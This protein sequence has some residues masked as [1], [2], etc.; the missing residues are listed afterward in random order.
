MDGTTLGLIAVAVVFVLDFTLLFGLVVLKD[1]HRRR[2]QRRE[3]RRARYVALL[4]RHLA[5]A[6]HIDEIGPDVADDDAFLDA[7]ID[8]RNV[9]SG[10]EV[11]TLSGIVDSL[12]LSDRQVA[13]LRSRFPLGRRLRAAVSLAE[14][15]DE[16]TASVL[17]EH[18]ADRE[19]EIRI[20][21]ARGLG[22][23]RHTV[24]ID[25]ILERLSIED[26][27]VRVRF[28]DT[29]VGF[30]ARATW[31]L[32]AY[33][34]VNLGHDGNKGVIEA[35]RVLGAIGDR[36]VGPTLAGIL[37][38]ARDPEV[39]IAAIE[40][41]GVVGGPL[42]V[43]PLEDAFGSSDWRLRAKSATALGEIG[44]PSVNPV[45]VNG[46]TDPEWWVRRNSAAALASLPGGETLLIE[47]IRSDDGFA[48]DAAAEALADSGALTSARERH[49]AGR[50]T[51]D[52]LLLLE[53]VATDQVVPA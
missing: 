8:L 26:S 23:M 44:D 49:E 34:R 10:A 7:V 53:H 31:P 25:A 5:T 51:P 40:S 45:L 47:A 37:R 3:Q 52:D 11:E 42:A 27:W 43:Q 50:A 12:G 19:P 16:S 35:I 17:I 18:L 32:V 13:A 4:S 21:C 2:A 46:L 22:R 14:M 29:L 24:A 9:L 15:G 28:A 30:G 33:I 1:V 41:L 36:D 39:K 48:R 6:T 20:Q 38:V